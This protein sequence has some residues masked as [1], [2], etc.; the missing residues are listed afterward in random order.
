[1]AIYRNYLWAGKGTSNKVSLV[2]WNLFCRQKREGGLGIREC[3]IWNE[4]VVAKYVWHIANKEDTMWVKCINHIYM[5]GNNWWQYNPLRDSCWYWRRICSIRDTY[6]ACYIENGWQTKIGKYTIKSGYH[7]RRGKL[8]QWAWSRGVWNKMNTLKHSFICWLAM[9]R[10][11][12]AKDKTLRMKITEDSD[13]M[14]CKGKTE[15]IDHLFFECT[16]SK[17]CLAK[18]LK[19]LGMNIKNTEVTGIWRRM[20]RIA[21]GKIGRSFTQAMLAAVIYHI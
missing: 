13:C 17:M 9:Q 19:W 12:L 14:L 16:F 5:K 6:P 4:A 21:K 15:S 8:E 7:W 18:V 1:M 2:A 10:K 11:L 3:I 20:T